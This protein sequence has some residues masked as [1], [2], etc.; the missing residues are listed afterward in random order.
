MAGIEPGSAIVGGAQEAPTG[1]IAV[2][3]EGNVYGSEQLRRYADRAI[4]AADRHV[5]RYPTAARTWVR[6][7]ELVA[8]GWIDTEA[9]EVVLDGPEARHRLAAWLGTSELDPDELLASASRFLMR[10]ELAE[11]RASGDP[12]RRF[13]ADWIERNLDV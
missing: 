13:V 9:G 3:Y 8:I 12:R 7:E 4:H 1:F 6:D 10:R 5:T 2:D 11:A